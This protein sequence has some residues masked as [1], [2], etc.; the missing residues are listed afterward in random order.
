MIAA[1][2]AEEYRNNVPT[3]FSEEMVNNGHN[4]SN[5]FIYGMRVSLIY[6]D[7]Y[8]GY[9][10][11]TTA[12]TVDT[13]QVQVDYLLQFE[14]PDTMALITVAFLKWVIGIVL[15]YVLAALV[16]YW[17]IQALKDVVTSMVTKKT[18]VK[19]CNAQG[20]CTETTI[21]EPDYMGMV[22]LI[23][24]GTAAAGI[25]YYIFFKRKGEK[26]S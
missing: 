11:P 5:V 23:V 6:V 19:T 7:S 15:Q 9:L 17:V 24:G 13:Y 3:K 20:I 14:S 12:V 21:T 2:F 1:K 8:T 10:F 22:T 25:V 18:T 4:V 16:A 26:K